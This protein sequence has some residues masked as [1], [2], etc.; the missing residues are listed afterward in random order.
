MTKT[1]TIAVLFRIDCNI[2]MGSRP[3]V[4]QNVKTFFF[5][6]LSDVAVLVVALWGLVIQTPVPARDVGWS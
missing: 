6:T 2:W 1:T 3:E 4:L 5:R